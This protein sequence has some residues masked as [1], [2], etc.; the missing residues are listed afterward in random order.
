MA[1]E[2]NKHGIQWVIIGIILLLTFSQK[3]FAAGFD[4]SGEW[5]NCGTTAYGQCTPGKTVNFQDGKCDLNTSSDSYTLESGKAG[6]YTLTISNFLN[7]SII[8]SVKVLDTDNI[9]L[10][11]QDGIV[12]SLMRNGSGAAKVVSSNTP[13][14]ESKEAGNNGTKE[15]VREN[16]SDVPAPVQ[17]PIQEETSLPEMQQETEPAPSAPQPEGPVTL[18]VADPVERFNET[19]VQ[20]VVSSLPD[21]EFLSFPGK[22]EKAFYQVLDDMVHLYSLGFSYYVDTAGSIPEYSYLT[23]VQWALFD[24]L[25]GND[26]PEFA[27]LYRTSGTDGYYVL[28]IYDYHTD[29]PALMYSRAL[30]PGFLP[31]Y[32]SYEGYL[33]LFVQELSGDYKLLTIRDGAISELHSATTDGKTC[34][35]DGYTVSQDVY[36]KTCNTWISLPRENSQEIKVL[37]ITDSAI[38]YE[39]RDIYINQDVIETIE[40]LTGIE[41]TE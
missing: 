3:S 21:P 1:N 11:T 4:I 7:A 8:L 17:S 28:D 9:E 41:E 37:A 19:G 12:V 16:S 6:D 13:A 39:E 26:D 5:T 14:E 32:V 35:V 15:G 34:L 29:G 38:G 18:R 30:A 40:K 20:N 10:T 22:D 33:C 2:K 23:G 24:D 31:G 25:S 27:I 36:L